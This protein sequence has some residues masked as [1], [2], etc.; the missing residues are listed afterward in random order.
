MVSKAMIAMCVL[1]LLAST[2]SA[3][4]MLEYFETF[5]ADPSKDTLITLVFWQVW[6]FFLPLLAG[7]FDVIFDYLWN[8]VMFELEFDGNT[9][10]IP[11][12]GLLGFVGVGNEQAF[13]EIIFGLIP[14]LTLNAVLDT[15]I[16]DTQTEI[17]LKKQLGITG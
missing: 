14:K 11:Y 10:Q 17:D 13:S 9:I 5:L 6:G 7:P 3:T 8:S 1:A 15:K 2:A 12:G 4:P 16:A